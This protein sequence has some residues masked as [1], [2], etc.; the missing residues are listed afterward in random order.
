MAEGLGFEFRDTRIS[1]RRTRQLV[2]TAS[3]SV[4]TEAKKFNDELEAQVHKLSESGSAGYGVLDILNDADGEL[5][6]AVRATMIGKA[7]HDEKMSYMQLLNKI[8]GSLAYEIRADYAADNLPEGMLHLTAY[9]PPLVPGAYFTIS[10]LL[11]MP[12]GIAEAKLAELAKREM[13][14]AARAIRFGAK[15]VEAATSGISASVSL[16]NGTTLSQGEHS[17]MHASSAEIVPTNPIF[18]LSGEYVQ[19]PHEPFIYLVGMTALAQAK[20]LVRA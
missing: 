14:R 2:V 5:A 1:G 9:T 13:V 3:E 16:L 17:A 8:I 20:Q 10:G 15:T 6:F 18:Y 12:A 19:D 11:K 4:Y 7:S